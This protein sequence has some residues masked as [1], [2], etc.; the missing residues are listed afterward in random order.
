MMTNRGSRAPIGPHHHDERH[1]GC[2]DEHG[3]DRQAGGNARRRQ[4]RDR[5]TDQGN[6]SRRKNPANRLLA[7]PVGRKRKKGAGTEQAPAKGVE[8]RAARLGRLRGDG[9]RD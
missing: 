3:L 1:D 8:K 5:A 2:H 9:G 4:E 6:A 7:P